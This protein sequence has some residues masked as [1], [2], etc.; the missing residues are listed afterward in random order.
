MG[1]ADTMKTAYRLS[2]GQYVIFLAAIMLFVVSSV[3][4][5]VGVCLDAGVLFRIG[6]I[7]GVVGSIWMFR[8]LSRNAIAYQYDPSVPRKWG[9]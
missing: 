9:M 1:R 3:R 2:D 8:W 5:V 6:A 7:A 4:L